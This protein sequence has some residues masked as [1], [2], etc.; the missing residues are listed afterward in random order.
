MACVPWEV[1][2]K[3]TALDLVI[4]EVKNKTEKG[5]PIFGSLDSFSIKRNHINIAMLNNIA[6]F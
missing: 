6:I 3:D 2:D 1:K 5:S 4:L